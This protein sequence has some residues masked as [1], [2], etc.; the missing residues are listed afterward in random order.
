MINDRIID[1][2]IRSAV[3]DLERLREEMSKASAED[4]HFPSSPE[5][6]VE[7]LS[8]EDDGGAIYS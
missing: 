8:W 2:A 5:V 3:A 4:T 1:A 7:L 6:P